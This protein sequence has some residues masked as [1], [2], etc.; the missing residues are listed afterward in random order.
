MAEA[1]LDD[2]PTQNDLL[3]AQML[4]HEFDKENDKMLHKEEEK[5]NGNSRGK[6]TSLELC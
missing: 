4:Q 2:D 5:F 6:A 3:L 1:F